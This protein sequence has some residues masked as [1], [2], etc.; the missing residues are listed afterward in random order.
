MDIIVYNY[1]TVFKINIIEIERFY[2][3]TIQLIFIIC[4]PNKYQLRNFYRNKFK[5]PN[6][7]ISANEG[8]SNNIVYESNTQVDDNQ[9]VSYLDDYVKKTHC[10]Y[11]D[12]VKG[13]LIFVFFTAIIV[14]YIYCSVYVL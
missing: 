7:K 6:F 10:M 8:L 5:I 3:P 4:C 11:Y 12:L 13:A 14:V 2:E 9:Y 1:G